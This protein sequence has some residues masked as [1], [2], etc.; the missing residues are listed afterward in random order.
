MKAIR[1]WP[2]AMRWARRLAHPAGVV[3]EH[4]VR[5]EPARGAVHED[6]R[7][8][9]LDLRRQVAVVV[10][11]GH[12][13]QAVHPAGAERQHQLLLTARVLRARPGEQQRPVRT[14]HVLDRAAQRRVEGVRH[15]FQHQPDARRAAG[16]QQ[17]RAVVAP[18][19][20][21]VDRGLDAGHGLRASP[22]VPRSPRGRPSSGRR[23]PARRHPSWW[24][25]GRPEFG[26][27][28]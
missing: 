14:R 19:A 15:V 25:G 26:S 4:H 16:A 2:C 27:R 13:H 1:R 20:E 9:R 8:A 5:V 18:E 12:H 3:G 7:D 24:A 22:R 23:P 21:R 17:P 6:G 28:S 11:R 10:A